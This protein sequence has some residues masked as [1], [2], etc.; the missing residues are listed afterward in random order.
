M[1]DVTYCAVSLELAK[2]SLL[3]IDPTWIEQVLLNLI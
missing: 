3:G 1:A 2:V